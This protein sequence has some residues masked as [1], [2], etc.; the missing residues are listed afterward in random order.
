MS[1]TAEL[2]YRCPLQCPY[3][4]NP[5]QLSEYQPELDTDTWSRVLREAADLGVIHA[6]FSG[7]E[8]LLRKDLEGLVRAARACDLYCD[9]STSAYTVT[10]DR[11][12]AL[13]DAGLDA[14]QVSLLDSRRKGNDF[15]GGVESFDKKCNAIR[16][17]KELG[18][19]LSLN[20]VLHR[21]NLDHV[22]EILRLA[23]DWGV[24][25]IELAHVQY[26]GWA[27]RNRA[28]LLPTRAQLEHARD[29]VA[30][31]QEEARGKLFILHVLPDFYQTV[32]K[33]CLQG[34]G[35]R[36]MTVAPDGAVLP[37]LS[38][39]EIPGLTFPNVA[40]ESLESIWFESGVFNRFRGTT[41]L[42]EPCQSC[43]RRDVDFGGCRCQAFLFTGDPARTDPVCHKAP[44]HALVEE[45]IRLAQQPAPPF[46]YRVF[47]PV[48]AASGE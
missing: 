27:F 31:F 19:P 1:L 9:L 30:Q 2:T 23:L 42:P 46:D 22:E 13:K 8:P 16:W 15:V 4:S 43:E 14:I 12:A 48:T 33:A 38:A 37:C 36:F 20:A 5:L 47:R 18:F 29:V 26:V 39:R 25:R 34:W 7:G 32:P 11:L 3:C 35:S 6:H 45:A 40:G 28:A 17:A 41:W 10:R 44:D 21:H 24:E